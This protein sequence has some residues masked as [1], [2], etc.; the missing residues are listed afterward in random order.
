MAAGEE[1]MSRDTASIVIVGDE[2]LK[3][4]TRDTNSHFLCRGLYDI[5]VKVLRIVIVPDDLPAIAAEVS[6]CASHYSFVLTSGGIGPTHDDVTYAGVAKAFNEE[7]VV[8]SD[9]GNILGQWCEGN[10]LGKNVVHKM[11]LVPQSSKLHYVWDNEHPDLIFPI[12][13]VRNVFIFPGIPAY[14]EHSFRFLKNIFSPTEAKPFFN[15][16]LYLS[17][18]EFTI[19][20]PLSQAVRKFEG[21]VSF[22]SYPEVTFAS[23]QNKITLEGDTEEIVLEAEGFLRSLLPKNSVVSPYVPS[24]EDSKKKLFSLAD[25]NGSG[26]EKTKVQFASLLKDS[27][28]KLQECFNRYSQEEVCLSFNGGKD[29]TVLLHLAYT[30]LLD[31]TVRENIP[32]KP[33]KTLYICPSDPFPELEDFIEQSV[34]RYNLNVIK[35][36]GSIKESLW[37]LHK[38]HSE[39]KAVLMG[40]RATD[41]YSSRLK[42]FQETDHDWPP[43]MR[44]SP[45]LHWG[46][47][48]V[49]GFLRTLH[50]PYCSLYDRGYTSL[51]NRANTRPNSRLLVQE[52]NHSRY[53][54][55]YMLK[56]PSEEREG[57]N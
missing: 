6:F 28:N 20:E 38:E 32:V 16:V 55:A 30:V 23:Y 41:P 42:A 13:S 11:S 3:G 35:F 33:L 44:I 15:K 31:W 48:D 2:I 40:T 47:H 18:T 14:L 54:P 39:I 57:R 37:K 49:W 21:R 17:T 50:I 45:L 8:N 51:G 29:C 10:G 53:R 7:L 25:T 56:D 22:G 19:T 1:R 24:S 4:H 27:I 26:E 5:G 34:K 36:S 46:Y 12:V 43:F 9:L 52:D